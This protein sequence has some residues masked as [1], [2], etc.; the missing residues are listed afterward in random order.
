MFLLPELRDHLGEGQDGRVERLGSETIPLGCD[1]AIGRMDSQ[2]LWLPTQ[3][4]ASQDSSMEWGQNYRAGDKE[5]RIMRNRVFI[6]FFN[7]KG[8]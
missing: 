1:R 7:I 5:G 8:S 3:D 2:Q 4:Q 6:S